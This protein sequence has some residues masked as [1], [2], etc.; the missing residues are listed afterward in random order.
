MGVRFQAKRSKQ[1]GRHCESDF[2][3]LSYHEPEI[4][5]VITRLRKSGEEKFATLVLYADNRGEKN[6]PI[7]FN[8]NLEIESHSVWVKDSLV[9]TFTTK[10]YQKGKVVGGIT[11]RQTYTLSKDGNT[12][13]IVEEFRAKAKTLMETDD[14]GKSKEVYT[15]EK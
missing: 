13:T 5:I 8:Q 11:T 3:S 10:L 14:K 15:R 9:R 2:R 12:L 7:P 4:R 1:R 6:L